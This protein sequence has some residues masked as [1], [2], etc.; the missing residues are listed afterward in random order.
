MGCHAATG[1]VAHCR[2]VAL[3]V[4][5]RGPLD[6][7]SVSGQ[8][9]G[10]LGVGFAFPEFTLVG[11]RDRV[12]AG[13]DV[14][15]EVAGTQQFSTVG[16]RSALVAADP[17]GV[18]RN[19]CE[20]GDAGQTIDAAEHGH[21]TTGGSK[22]LRADCRPESGYAGQDFGIP[23]AAKS[24][25][26]ERFGFGDFVIE[27][28]HIL[29]RS[30]DDLGRELLA[31]DRDTLLF[32]SIYGGLGDRNSVAHLTLTQPSFQSGKADAPDR[33]RGLIAITWVSGR[34][35]MQRAA[36]PPPAIYNSTHDGRT[37]SPRALATHKTVGLRP[38]TRKGRDTC[39]FRV[40]CTSSRPTI[41]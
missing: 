23:V 41:T 26:D 27:G 36:I 1:L 12:A 17:A 10:R 29:G 21:L 20:S 37:R 28:D 30:D 8:C 32:G 19:R 13:C 3:E 24:L 31:T 15:G 4:A 33:I 16:P 5:E 2:C 9:D 18:F 11:T 25:G 40:I 38:P 14:C 22:E 6:V 35:V 39:H 7:E 34:S